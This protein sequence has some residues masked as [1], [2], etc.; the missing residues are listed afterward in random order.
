MIL[1]QLRFANSLPRCTTVRRKQNRERGETGQRGSELALVL[2]S[3]RAVFHS[4]AGSSLEKAGASD[5]TNFNT[6][7]HGH[8]QML[9][10]GELR[11]D[12]MREE[13]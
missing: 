3:V 7:W 9:M 10:I 8:C 4:L 5:T 11:G 2:G 13:S 12:L 6:Q 1:A